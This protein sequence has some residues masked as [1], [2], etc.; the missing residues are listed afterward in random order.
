MADTRLLIDF[1]TG[2]NWEMPISI[3]ERYHRDCIELKL[4]VPQ[5]LTCIEYWLTTLTLEEKRMIVCI[6]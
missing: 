2:E 6:K 5:G 4:E 1:A 3:Y